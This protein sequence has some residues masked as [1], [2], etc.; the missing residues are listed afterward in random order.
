MDKQTLLAD[1]RRIHAEL[2][3][4]AAGLDDAAWLAEPAGM[5]GWTRKDVLAHCEFW[6]ANSARVAGELRAGREPYDRSEPF[7]VD[8]LNARIMV[9][10]RARSLDDVKAGEADAYRRVVAAVEA[11]SEAELFEAGHFA[12]LAGDRLADIVEGDTSGHW[13]EH[14]PHL[15][16]G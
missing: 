5:P 15:T 7:D 4:A 2:L 8:A 1:I 12:W 9:E 13:P 3:A 11:S 6:S 14:V 16:A 10:G